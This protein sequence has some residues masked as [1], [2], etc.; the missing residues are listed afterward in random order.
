MDMSGGHLLANR[1]IGFQ[2]FDYRFEQAHGLMWRI[3][4]RKAKRRTWQLLRS[5]SFAI[6]QDFISLPARSESSGY[7]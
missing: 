3:I 4:P 7:G 2:G 6:V 5:D 1:I